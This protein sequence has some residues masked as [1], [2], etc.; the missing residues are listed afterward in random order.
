M[1]APATAGIYPFEEF[2]EWSKEWIEE[3]RRETHVETGTEAQ[4][5]PNE[6]KLCFAPNPN[7]T[8]NIGIR[9]YPTWVLVTIAGVGAFLQLGILI[10]AAIARYRLAWTRGDFQDRY[11]VPMLVIGT[12]LLSTGMVRC[13]THI[14]ATRKQLCCLALGPLS[15]QTGLHS[16][17]LNGTINGKFQRRGGFAII[18]SPTITT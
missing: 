18:S 13:A 6:G 12:G 14:S 7:L 2:V 17:A 8:L 3:R 16:S 11:G 10:W 9:F 5:E 4:E 15:G 1:S